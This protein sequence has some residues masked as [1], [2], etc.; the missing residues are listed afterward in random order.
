MEQKTRSTQSTPLHYPRINRFKSA[1]NQLRQGVMQQV[2]Q[3]LQK[4][5]VQQLA[6]AENLYLN[7]IFAPVQEFENRQC[8]VRGEIPASLNGILLRM[9]PNP[10]QVDS[11]LHQHWFAGDGMLHGL[12]LQQGQVQWFK[13]RYIASDRIQRAKQKLPKPGFRRG[14]GDVVNT[15][16]FFYAGQ[17]WALVEAGTFPVCLDL[18]LNTIKHQLFRSNADLPFTAHPHRDPHSGH[19]HAICYDALNQKQIFYEVF[20]RVGQLVHVAPIAVQHG[21]MIHDCAVT[22]KDI[23]IFDFPVIFSKQRLLQGSNMPYQWHPEHGARIGAMPHYGVASQIQW[24]E[25]EPCFVFHAANAY[26]TSDHGIVLDVVVH[27]RM[28]EQSSLG[29]FEQQACVLERWQINLRQGS[30]QR[31]VLDAQAQEFPRIDERDLTQKHRYIYS[32]SF[33]PQ[34]ILQSNQ[35]LVHDTQLGLKSSYC[36]GADWV[37]G[38]AVF[39]PIH[40]DARQGEGYLLCYVHHLKGLSSKVAILAV[41]GIELRLQAEIDLATVVP[42]GFHANWVGLSE[43]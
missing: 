5:N 32:A 25:L 40:A 14:P 26:R 34:Q 18:E 41:D 1:V 15:N 3:Y 42:M 35:L 8:V 2:M 21:P 17:I 31:Q 13:S 12:K 11:L 39:Q 29:P 19:L 43:Q 24:I 27:D 4:R 38:E 10:Y 36:F 23:L 6:V 7:G 9:G 28:F 33:D 30:V 22:E 37:V 20:D 16:A